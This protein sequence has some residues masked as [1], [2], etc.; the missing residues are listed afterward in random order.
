ML[1]HRLR[2]IDEYKA[3]TEAWKIV[4][5][6]DG[7]AEPE[8]VGP[9]PQEYRPF[10]DIVRVKI[11][12]RWAYF[13]AEVMGSPGS[14]GSMSTA[15]AAQILDVTQRTI[16]RWA[17]PGPARCLDV[18]RTAGG[19]KRPGS[20]RITTESVN[21]LLRWRNGEPGPLDLGPTARLSKPAARKPDTGPEQ[22]AGQ[23][24]FPIGEDADAPDAQ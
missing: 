11:G 18:Y 19:R 14:D 15:E 24:A 22:I 17:Q 20:W 21:K 3:S 6:A 10:T 1:V 16:R 4:G 8:R 9:A 7:P 12:G 23:A 5:A 2:H 13:L